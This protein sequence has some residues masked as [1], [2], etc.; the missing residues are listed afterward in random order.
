MIPQLR[1][2]VLRRLAR[3]LIR[4][5]TF[6]RQLGELDANF[7]PRFL[8]AASL[9]RGAAGEEAGFIRDLVNAEDN[10][11]ALW[12]L[13]ET[14]HKTGGFFVEFGAADGIAASTTHLLEKE[15]GWRGIVAEPNPSW[16]HALRQNRRA[17]IDPRC[18]FAASGARVKFA[19][20]ESALLAT[21]ADYVSCDGHAQSRERHH[22]IEVETVSLNDLLV[23]HDAPRDIDFISI[24]TEGSEY[25]ILRTF[26][27]NHWRVRLFSVEHNRTVRQAQIH[28]LMTRNGYEQRY[29]SYPVIDSWYRRFDR[30]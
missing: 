22:V 14:N 2:A 23:S 20:T 15:F 7:D 24:D 6:R 16:H 8:R 28:E 9:L 10:D 1:E 30:S 11:I 17:A 18:V 19:V 5:G 21:I 27:F 26:D 3:V 13:H 4:S 12:V 29:P 25:D